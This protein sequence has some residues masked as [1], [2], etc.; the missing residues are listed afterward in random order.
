MKFANCIDG[1]WGTDDWADVS[2]LTNHMAKQ[3][4]VDAKRIGILGGS[5]GGFMTTWALSHSERYRVGISMRQLCDWATQAGSSDIGF[6]D[7]FHFGGK[8]P[9]EDP[10]AYFRASP[11]AYVKDIK[12]P[13]LII[14]SEGDLRCP[15]AQAEALFIAMK[16][17]NRAPCEFIRFEG[18]FHGLSRNGKP[19]NREERL[20]RIVDWFERHL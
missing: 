10:A 1:R 11:Y 18:E 6:L 17:L 7:R 14:H 20:R 9:W 2:A 12:S 16:T 4:F 5:Y 19:R 3:G 13:L 8:E 15:V